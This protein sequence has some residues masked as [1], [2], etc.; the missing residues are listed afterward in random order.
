MIFVQIQNVVQQCIRLSLRRHFLETIFF[1]TRDSRWKVCLVEKSV[2]E[3]KRLFEFSKLLLV[4][5]GL[6]C[7][8]FYEGKPYSLT[9]KVVCAF[10]ELLNRRKKQAV[11][12]N[13]QS[14]KVDSVDFASNYPKIV[15]QN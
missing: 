7:C 12:L 15:S 13:V 1:A 9:V 4:S 5:V 11:L 10:V 8:L 2:D 3:E 14:E 6:Q